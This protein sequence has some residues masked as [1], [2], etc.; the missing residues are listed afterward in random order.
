MPVT[1]EDVSG[2]I[3]AVGPGKVQIEVGRCFAEEVDEA[4]EVEVQVYGIY[5]GDAQA[6]GDE[7]VGTTATAD[8]EVTLPTGILHDVPVDEKVRHEPF[9]DDDVE[10]LVD[11][12]V[13]GLVHTSVPTAHTF[14]GLLEQDVCI[15]SFRPREESLVAVLPEH[16][17]KIT[18]IQQ[19]I[20]MVQQ[21]RMLR[22]LRTHLIR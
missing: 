17:R 3:V 2:H 13:D 6:V 14:E 5:I 10:L 11:A 12:L 15:F 18:L 7:T 19:G 8:G 21:V 22:I 16:I 9:F 20:G 4:F 1:V